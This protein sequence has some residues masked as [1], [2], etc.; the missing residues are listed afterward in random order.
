MNSSGLITGVGLG[1]ATVSATV[2]GVTATSGNITVT[3]QTLCI[4]TASSA[5]LPIRSAAPM[6]GTIVPHQRRIPCHHHQR[7]FLAR[8]YGWRIR[9]FRLCVSA[10]R[11]SDQYHLVD[12]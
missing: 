5:M 6:G 3:P 7:P 10:Q 9:F 8:E 1:T 12:G 2:G 4:A 11:D